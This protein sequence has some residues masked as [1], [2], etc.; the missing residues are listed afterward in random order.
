MEPPTISP[1]LGIR[2]STDSVYLRSS[3]HFCMQKALISA[4][5]LQQ[6]IVNTSHNKFL[7]AMSHPT[8]LYKKVLVYDI[9]FN[10]TV[11]SNSNVVSCYHKVFKYYC[12]NFIF[13][14]QRPQ[15]PQ[16]H[17]N[18]TLNSKT[19]TDTRHLYSSNHQKWLPLKFWCQ[20]RKERLNGSTNNGDM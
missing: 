3:G 20:N 4:G 1:T 5:N 19:P 2:I 18:I 9:I 11:R 13:S 15:G 12:F 7:T 8:L 10:L 16:K 6:L 14:K 17:N